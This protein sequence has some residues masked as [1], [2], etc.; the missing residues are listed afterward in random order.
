MK[1]S[2]KECLCIAI[3]AHRPALLQSPLQREDVVYSDNF[4]APFPKRWELISRDKRFP[5]LHYFTS[6]SDLSFYRVG[7][8]RT[9]AYRRR[10][11]NFI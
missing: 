6:D 9:H 10:D 7:G 4:W 3:E 2:C 1:I 11:T 8:L 5:V